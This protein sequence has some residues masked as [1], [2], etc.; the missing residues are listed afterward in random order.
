VT[1]TVTI[2]GVEGDNDTAGEIDGAGEISG[3][4]GVAGAME[5]GMVEVEEGS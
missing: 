2:S 1:I 5:S 4:V 3:V